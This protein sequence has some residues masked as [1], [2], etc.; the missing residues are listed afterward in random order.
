MSSAIRFNLDQSKTLSLNEHFF[1]P[2]PYIDGECC[3]TNDAGEVSLWNCDWQVIA[4]Q[5]TDSTETPSSVSS[6]HFGSHPRC[7]I[8][9]NTTIVKLYDLRVCFCVLFS[10]WD[11]FSHE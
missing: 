5:N 6:V 4:F 11:F 7:L 2:S 3:V 9:T 1:F 8:N 10:H